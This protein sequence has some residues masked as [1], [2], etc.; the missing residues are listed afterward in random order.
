MATRLLTLAG[1]A[2]C[3]VVLPAL[4]DET[5]IDPALGCAKNPAVIGACFAVKG[6]IAVYNGSPS[7]RIHPYGTKRLLGVVPSEEEI[8]PAELKSAIGLDR[9]AVADMQ[10]CP[11]TKLMP[12]KMQL[13]CIES[14]K[15]IRPAR[16]N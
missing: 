3:L 16:S 10:V 14:A 1:L 8:M 6:R 4:A 2:G 5:P 9:D 13:V 11:F 15:N 12:G 7:V